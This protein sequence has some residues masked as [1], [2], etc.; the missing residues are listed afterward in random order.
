LNEADK[1]YVI[2]GVITDQPN[3]CRILVSRTMD[4]GDENTFKGVQGAEVSVRLPSGQEIQLTETAPGVYENAL[5]KGSPGN[6]YQ[7]TV[8]VSGNTFTASSMMPEKVLLDSIFIRE[9][10]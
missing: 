6:T 3:S 5:L 8:I 2:E 7:L 4:F 9:N 10:T 1:K